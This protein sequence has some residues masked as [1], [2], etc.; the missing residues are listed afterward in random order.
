M[1]RNIK[2]SDEELGNKI[3]E[4]ALLYGDGLITLAT[5]QRKFGVSYKRACQVVKW[6]EDN[7]H[8]EVSEENNTNKRKG[9]FVVGKI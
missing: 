2:I 4:Y 7:G 9:R 8:L 6:L 5:I 3:V 1:I